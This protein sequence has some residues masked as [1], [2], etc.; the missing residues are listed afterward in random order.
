[1]RFAIQWLY[2]GVLVL[3]L[4]QD[5]ALIRWLF[6]SAVLVVWWALV[7][8]TTI[9]ILGGYAAALALVLIASCAIAR[10]AMHLLT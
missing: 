4:A 1:M 8:T 7:Q 2:A 10:L 5:S 9:G 6:I 3:V